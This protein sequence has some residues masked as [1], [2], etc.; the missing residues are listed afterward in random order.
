MRALEGDLSYEI[1]DGKASQVLGE[2]GADETH[3]ELEF[4]EAGGRYCTEFV[5][6]LKKGKDKQTLEMAMLPLG[7]SVV[8]VISSLGTKTLGKVRS[9]AQKRRGLQPGGWAFGQRLSLATTPSPL[10]GMQEIVTCALP[11]C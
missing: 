8:A 5:L 7:T 11:V 4:D 3:E 9:S 6:E 2:I 1:A 10:S